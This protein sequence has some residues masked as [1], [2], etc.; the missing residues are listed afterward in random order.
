MKKFYVIGMVGLVIIVG[1]LKIVSVKDEGY[2][3][4]YLEENTLVSEV[5][6]VEEEKIKIHIIG[7]VVSPRNL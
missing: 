7:E 1:F 4:I 5:L 3:D 2:E 6:E